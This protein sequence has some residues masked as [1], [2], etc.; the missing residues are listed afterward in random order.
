MATDAKTPEHVA[1]VEAD[2]ETK[3][4]SASVADKA[5][6]AQLGNINE[7][8]A[9]V[10]SALRAYPWAV[11]WTL[12]VLMSIIMEG[13]D[14]ILIGNFFGYPSFQAQVSVSRGSPKRSLSVALTADSVS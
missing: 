5:G 4:R 1:H 8:S 10:R 2:L 13:Y 14:T 9:T 7:H 11:F 3:E 6:D 12:L